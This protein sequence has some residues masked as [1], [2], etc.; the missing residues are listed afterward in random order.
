MGKVLG[1]LLW[2]ITIG[3]VILFAG[4]WWWFPEGIS[5]YAPE[6]DRQF[7]LTLIVVA[8]VFV[9]AQVGL[10]W[11]IMSY[12]SGKRGAASYSHGNN[13]LEFTWTGITAAVFIVLAIF[14]QRVW[15][16][17]HFNEPP[18]GALQI[19]VTAQQF[20]WNFRYPGPD[21]QF[22]KTEARLIDDAGG[23]PLGLDPDD[24]VGKDDFWTTTLTIPQDKPVNLILRSKDVIH[25]FFVP[26]LRIKQDTVP[27]MLINLHFIA[28]KSGKYEVA[29]A[30]LCGL[31][32]YKMKSFMDV[33]PE[34]DY[35]SF[36]KQKAAS[37]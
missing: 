1:L 15:A 4:K 12:G 18:P 13:T 19:E 14:G 16:K 31:G 33:V 37:R 3:T 8:I 27:G 28:H 9:L 21:G 35:E 5:N 10:G 36:L 23:N 11:V 22:G 30:E 26:P 6:I 2:I 34:A 25:D 29:C 32:H 17:L 20:A 24:P 7:N